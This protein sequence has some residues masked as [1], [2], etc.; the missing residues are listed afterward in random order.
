MLATG[1]LLHTQGD[2]DGA[3]KHL[4]HGIARLW[5]PTSSDAM[6]CGSRLAHRQWVPEYPAAAADATAG[7]AAERPHNQAQVQALQPT[8][9]LGRRV[10]ADLAQHCTGASWADLQRW[11]L[12]LRLYMGAVAGPSTHFNIQQQLLCDCHTLLSSPSAGSNPAV[13]MWGQQLVL[14]S[15]G[16]CSLGRERGSNLG[17]LF[18]AALADGER[19]KCEC[20]RVG[21]MLWL[22]QL[23]VHLGTD[24]HALHMP[25]VS[26]HASMPLLLQSVFDAV[27][28]PIH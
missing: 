20:G 15:G 1:V 6:A 22:I 23:H 19:R 5:P 21:T 4:S 25:P 10:A 8:T 3:L 24:A 14:L 28:N 18:E 2:A 27:H 26:P 11:A 7:E 17:A 9:A 12:T 16:W 13:A